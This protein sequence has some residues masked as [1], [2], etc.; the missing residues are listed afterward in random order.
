MSEF[1]L[2]LERLTAHEKECLAR[3]EGINKR[4]D[5][6]GD[7]MKRLEGWVIAIYPFFITLLLALKYFE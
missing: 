3:Y 6:G 1:D 2:A 5:E 4:L 7:R